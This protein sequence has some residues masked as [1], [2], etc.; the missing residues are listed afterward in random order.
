[1]S[2]SLQLKVKV[3]FCFCFFFSGVYLRNLKTLSPWEQHAKRVVSD[4]PGLVDFAI[5][6]VNSFL[7]VKFLGEFKLQK[8]C[9]QSCS[10]IIF[11]LWA[12]G[13]T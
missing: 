9:N 2:L 3:F 8:N 7:T 12:T 6:P 13:S 11:F 5:E 4:T 1:M 10:S